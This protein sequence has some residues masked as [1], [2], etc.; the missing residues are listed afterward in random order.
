MDPEA[1][2]T[3]TGGHALILSGNTMWWQVRYNEDK[4]K[5]I[6]YFNIIKGDSI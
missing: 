1:S 2:I 4:T 5:L 6:C 3:N